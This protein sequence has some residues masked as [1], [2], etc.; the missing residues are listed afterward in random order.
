MKDLVRT[1][2]APRSIPNFSGEAGLIASI[3]ALLVMVVVAP[4]SSAGAATPSG[5][6]GILSP[7][8]K[9]ALPNSELVTNRT[10]TV[11]EPKTVH[12]IWSGPTEKE[13]TS[14]RERI[15]ISNHTKKTQIVTFEGR[16]LVKL[17]PK[18]QF[19]ACF[20]G[21]GRG[22]FVFGIKKS[23]AQLTVTVG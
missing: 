12:A 13:C 8:T 23:K 9:P 15:T 5:V 14:S 16:L 20:W 3:V 18:Y 10:T 7:I 4:A 6:A 21:T 2:R 22:G 17:P 1:R 11:Y 19:G